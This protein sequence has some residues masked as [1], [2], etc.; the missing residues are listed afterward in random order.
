MTHKTL[1]KPTMSKQCQCDVFNK[2]GQM[3]QKYVFL[4]LGMSKWF[5]N[6]G[7]LPFSHKQCIAYYI[8]VD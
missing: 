2:N 1:W 3:C 4:V 8:V 7:C 6:E 5:N